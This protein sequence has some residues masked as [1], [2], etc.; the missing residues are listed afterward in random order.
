MWGKMTSKHAEPFDCP[1]CNGRY[2]L[3]RAEADSRSFNG[4]IECYYCGGPLIGR[5]GKFVLKY[6]VADKPRRLAKT[7]RVR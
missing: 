5:E 2:K 3:V 1:T 7:S 4:T 6:F